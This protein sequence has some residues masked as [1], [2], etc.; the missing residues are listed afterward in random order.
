MRVEDGG[1]KVVSGGRGKD[2]PGCYN[3]FAGL[4]EWN[5]EFGRNDR[6]RDRPSVELK[7]G[8]IRNIA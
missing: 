4:R 2:P 3:E 7:N 5:G 1:W 8:S 6:K